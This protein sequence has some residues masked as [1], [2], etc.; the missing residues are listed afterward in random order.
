ME[1]IGKELYLFEK[2]VHWKKYWSNQIAPY[3]HG[4]VLEVGA[5]IGANAP[6]F[7][8]SDFKK[9]T[10]LEP[11]PALLLECRKRLGN[12]PRYDFVTGTIGDIQSK[13]DVIFYID[14]LEHIEE[15]SAEMRRAAERLNPGGTLI[16]LVPAHQW[17][18][19]P[20]DAAA[21]HFRRYTKKSL[22]SVG[23]PT[24]TLK[25]L[26]YLDC[27]GFFASLTN[28]ILLKQSVPSDAQIKTWDSLL[29]PVSTLI[30]PLIGH[31]MGKSVLGIWT[32]E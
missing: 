5:G 3:I 24:T 25:R 6:L 1:Y 19:S 14:V 17:L 10:C 23:A 15:D 2:A 7:A 9:W 31:T 16:I 11:D 4:D 27:V 32:K 13:F 22:K 20:F 30:D 8:G 21:G 26:I 12:L 29:V 28:K 18:F